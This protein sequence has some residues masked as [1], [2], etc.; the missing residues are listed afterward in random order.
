MYAAQ[1]DHLPVLKM[2]VEHKADVLHKAHVSHVPLLWVHTT[3][4]TLRQ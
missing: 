1:Y 3:F 4:S 2:L